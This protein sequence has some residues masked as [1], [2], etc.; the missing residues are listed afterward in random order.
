MTSEYLLI[1]C[2]VKKRKKPLS[3]VNGSLVLAGVGLKPV[4]CC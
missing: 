3:Y 4:T 2:K 1:L